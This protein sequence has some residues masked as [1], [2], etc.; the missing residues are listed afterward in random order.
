LDSSTG[1]KSETRLCITYSVVELPAEKMSH[2]VSEQKSENPDIRPGCE[3]IIK[4]QTLEKE[5]EHGN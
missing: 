4:K 3:D 1:Y 2:R 5:D